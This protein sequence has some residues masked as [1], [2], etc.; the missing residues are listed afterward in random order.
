MDNTG[1]IAITRQSSLLKELNSVANNVAN[2]STPG[3][4]REGVVFSEHVEAL[5]VAE[6]SIS[7]AT[8]GAYY[9]DLTQG[10]LKQT[11]G[12]FDLA[13]EGPGFFQI[14]TPEGLRLTRSGSFSLNAEGQIVTMDG[15]A[16]LGDGGGPIVT[17]QG[18]SDFS[19]AADG[20]ISA[21]GDP[22][23]RVGLVD[24]APETLRREGA[25]LFSTTGALG[26]AP[27]GRVLQ[28]FVEGSNVNPV[29]EISRLVEVQRAYELSQSF[30]E[31]EDERI[32]KT[33]QTM[34]ETR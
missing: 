16:L 9:V 15:R 27:D 10:S 5:D 21:D 13:I 6:G 32:M 2:M 25:N 20:T 23:D 24:V 7:L 4:K 17:P 34:G 31:Q 1:Y 19:I 33:V 12:Q 3:F 22:I 26:P 28:G 29:Q 14:D 30:L 18:V 8:A 11:N